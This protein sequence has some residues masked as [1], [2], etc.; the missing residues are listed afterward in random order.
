MKNLPNIIDTWETGNFV[1]NN[2]AQTRVTITPDWW[3]NK[4]DKV[5]GSSPYGPFRWFQSA[6]NDQNEMEIPNIK[7][8]D[9]DRSIDTDIAS[10]NIVMYNQWMNINGEAPELPYQLGKPGYFSW[11]RAK[12]PESIARWNQTA[13]AWEDV[14]LPNAMI[15]TFQGYGGFEEDG[16][17]MS[18]G[19]AVIDGDLTLTGVWLVDS[20]N[21][22]SAGQLSLR[23]RDMG[24]LLAV[25]QV[26][27]PL[28]P[29]DQYGAAGLEFY[30]WRFETYDAPFNPIKYHAPPP[31]EFYPTYNTSSTDFWYGPNGDVLGHRGTDSVDGNHDTFALSVGNSA[32]EMSFCVDYWE[33]NVGEYINQVYVDTW[34]GNYTMYISVLENGQWVSNGEGAIPYDHTPLC[35]T[36]TCVDTGADIPFVLKAATDWEQ[37]RYFILD[38]FFHAQR[39]RITFRNH[40]ASPWGPFF[41]RCGIREIKVA[42]GQNTGYPPP[43]P[44]VFSIETYNNPD[45]VFESGYW[46]V[47][48]DGKQFA[49]GD[50]RIHPKNSPYGFDS[51]VQRIRSNPDGQGY[52]LMQWDGRVHTFG[53]ANWLGDARTAYWAQTGYDDAGWSNICEY[54]TQA[55]GGAAWNEQATAKS[56]VGNRAPNSFQDPTAYWCGPCAWTV[57]KAPIASFFARWDVTS[58]GGAHDLYIGAD[59]SGEIYVDGAKIGDVSSYLY[60]RHFSITLPAGPHVISMR[61]TNGVSPVVNRN[62]CAVVWVLEKDGA[63][64]AHSDHTGKYR[65]DTNYQ[66]FCDMAVTPSGNGYW[67]AAHTGE[68]IAFGDATDFTNIELT[69]TQRSEISPRFAG[70]WQNHVIEAIC[71]HPTNGGL[72]VLLGHGQILNL[73]AAPDLG[74][75]SPADLARVR[76]FES[77]KSLRSTPD[78]TGLYVLNGDGKIAVIGTAQSYGDVVQPPPTPGAP[79]ATLFEVFRILTWDFALCGQGDGLGYYEQ[80]ANGDITI[81]GDCKWYGKPG[82]TATLRMDGNYCVDELTEVLTKR[83]WLTYR[84]VTEGDET[85]AIN[86]ATGMSEWTP[87]ESIFRRDVVGEPMMSIE[88]RSVS[89]LTTPDHRWLTVQNQTGEFRWKTTETLNQCDDIPLTAPRSDNPTG[90]A[91]SDEFVELIGWFWAEGCLS[92]NRPSLSQ[93]VSVNPAQVERIEALLSKLFGPPGRVHPFRS[94]DQINRALK[95]LHEGASER[96]VQR[97]LEFSDVRSVS[98]LAKN[99][100]QYGEWSTHDMSNGVRQFKLSRR[101]YPVFAAVMT[102]KKALLPDFLL[103]LSTDQLRLLVDSGLRADGHFRLNVSSEPTKVVTQVDRGRMDSFQMACHLAGYATSIIEKEGYWTLTVLQKQTKSFHPDLRRDQ[104]YTGTIWCPTLKHHNWLARRNGKVCFTGNTDYADIVKLFLAWSGWILYSETPDVTDNIPP[105]FGNIESTGAFADDPIPS[106]EWDKTPPLDCINKLKEI[107][108][109]LFWIDDSGAA[110]FE[111]ANWWSIGNFWEDG[112]PTDFLPEID[113]R[114]HLTNY[115]VDY[116]DDPIRSEVIISTEEPVQGNSSTIVTDYVPNSADVL[117]GMCKPAM[118]VN[119]L[120][121]SKEEQEIMAELISL[122]IWFQQRI[123]SVQCPANPA[124]QV[125]DQIRIFER[126]TAETYVHYVRGVSTHHDLDTGEYTMTLTT[127]WMGDAGDWVITRDDVPAGGTPDPNG[128]GIIVGNPGSSNRIQISDQLRG[129]L[130]KNQSRSVQV[131]RLNNFETNPSDTA[132]LQPPTTGPG[133]GTGE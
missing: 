43:V 119:G 31:K 9:I 127:H 61:I 129:W 14:F 121:K 13:N 3:L 123:G 96:D 102:S 77:W 33:Y 88:G 100:K 35:D 39:I 52:Y 38:R 45:V 83:G 85:L 73:G 12:S 53:S 72:W 87:I 15:R 6:A 10:C 133:A 116:S 80:H 112:T 37:G 4:T 94:A 50:A 19:D 34:G 54:A 42:S 113:E 107:V 126:V 103:S 48:D 115:S 95:M 70:D 81:F 101:L 40:Q 92:D 132:T 86:P 11:G 24:K 57:N 84:E 78:G 2:R 5:Y 66:G 130:N 104:T 32:P 63:I 75:V 44:W 90:D 91:Y 120:F 25:Q 56:L 21:V 69:P 67:L 59:N 110:R 124:I 16:T 93:S 79:Q 109:Y 64:V 128:S 111:S 51:R 106:S 22:S 62:P 97:F 76:Q 108:G 41:Y 36:Q 118:W 1:G 49:F 60:A 105:V 71:A 46:C 122:H 29:H 47:A 99:P 65:I 125:N 58:T 27:P 23:C 18:I 28:I 7:S 98:R 30:R 74:S 131:A 8:V 20:V 17:P 114:I 55:A 68:L 117:H 89:C 26:Y 82:D